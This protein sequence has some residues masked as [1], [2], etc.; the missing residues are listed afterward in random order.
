MPNE[1]GEVR[2]TVAGKSGTICRNATLKKEKPRPGDQDA[3]M[4][5]PPLTR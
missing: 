4:R 1:R 2:G 5:D 3:A